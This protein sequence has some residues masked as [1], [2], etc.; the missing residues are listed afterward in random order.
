MADLQVK[1]KNL[2]QKGHSRI[3]ANQ[4]T[5]LGTCVAINTMNQTSLYCPFMEKMKLYNLTFFY[6]Q[7]LT[8]SL[9]IVETIPTKNSKVESS[10]HYWKNSNISKE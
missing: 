3:S 2:Q 8:I 9:T 6:V 7:T 1:P 4:D 10:Q 5:I